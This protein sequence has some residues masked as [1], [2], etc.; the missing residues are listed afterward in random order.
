MRKSIRKNLP[1]SILIARAVAELDNDVA[2]PVILRVGNNLETGKITFASSTGA[3][4][5]VQ[6]IVINDAKICHVGILLADAQLLR[7]G[8]PT[9]N[10]IGRLVLTPEHQIR[11]VNVMTDAELPP[12]L[13][14]ALSDADALLLAVVVHLHGT[15]V[16]AGDGRPPLSSDAACARIVVPVETI[17]ADS[18]GGKDGGGRPAVCAFSKRILEE[19]FLPLG[20]GFLRSG[21]DDGVGPGPDRTIGAIGTGRCCC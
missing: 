19:I 18:L 6:T 9:I 8:E 10:R 13:A 20:D 1:Q 4:Q 3:D 21:L 12:V 5:I 2:G 11:L 16:R 14:D 7:A 15:A 17:R